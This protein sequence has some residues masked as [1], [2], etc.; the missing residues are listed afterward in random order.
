MSYK[1]SLLAIVLALFLTANLSLSA[2][3]LF[4]GGE[5]EEPSIPDISEESPQA[6]AQKND[7]GLSA[8][9]VQ[10]R[11]FM[12][13]SEQNLVKAVQ[14]YGEKMNDFLPKVMEDALAVTEIESFQ[15]AREEVD[16]ACRTIEKFPLKSVPE[17]FKNVY[18]ALFVEAHYARFMISQTI[19]ENA[20]NLPK[21]YNDYNN[22]LTNFNNNFNS[23]CDAVRNQGIAT[24]NGMGLFP[25]VD[26]DKLAAERPKLTETMN[27][28]DLGIPFGVSKAYVM[29]VQG[30]VKDFADTDKLVYPCTFN[31]F[32]GERIYHFNKYGQMDAYYYALGSKTGNAYNDLVDL[33]PYCMRYFVLSTYAQAQVPQQQADGTYQ[34]VFDDKAQTVVMHNDPKDAEHPIKVDVTGKTKG[35]E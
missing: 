34:V 18:E 19:Q 27:V 5:S 17:V 3:S 21:D 28:S 35:K 20:T 22:R 1:K 14:L 25:A 30:L 33:S 26:W 6:K 7:E 13:T 10:V 29:G 31:G 15:K 23:Y 8:R 16:K 11:D 24:A 12:V 9:E 4:G 2:C 32:S